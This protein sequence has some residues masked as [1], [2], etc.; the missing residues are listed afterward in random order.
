MAA[1]GSASVLA[2]TVSQTSRT[3]HQLIATSPWLCDPA[4]RNTRSKSIRVKR[5][6][7]LAARYLTVHRGEPSR[8]CCKKAVAPGSDSVRTIVCY[9]LPG[10][11]L[12][13]SGLIFRKTGVRRGPISSH[14]R[15]WDQ[16]TVRVFWLGPCS[17]RAYAVRGGPTGLNRHRRNAL[18]GFR[19]YPDCTK[20]FVS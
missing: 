4:R 8:P 19:D 15:R 3:R 17:R 16:S 14:R 10:D 13:G 18:G 2:S 1:R 12:T 11:R 7:A 5:H 9:A 6:N 20:F